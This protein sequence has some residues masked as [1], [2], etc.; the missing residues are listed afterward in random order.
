MTIADEV[1]AGVLSI[2]GLSRLIDDNLRVAADLDITI[3]YHNDKNTLDIIG[4]LRRFGSVIHSR[5]YQGKYL[6]TRIANLHADVHYILLRIEQREKKERQRLSVVRD[7][8]ESPRS[9]AGP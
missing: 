7:N 2:K 6:H 5:N 3:H 9:Q 8:Q 4:E 1:R